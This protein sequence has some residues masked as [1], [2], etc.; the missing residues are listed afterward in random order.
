[1]PIARLKT[2]IQVA[3]LFF[4]GLLLSGCAAKPTTEFDSS[5]DF[6][7]PKSFAWISKNPLKV[8]E[9]SLPPN[10]RDEALLMD[11]T[12]S[13]LTTK[14]YTLVD[15]VN[16][17]DI[18]VAFRIG[19]REAMVLVNYDDFS[20]TAEQIDLYGNTAGSGTGEAVF[21]TYTD[22]QLAIDMFDVGTKRLIWRNAHSTPTPQ[23]ARKD[24]HA[25]VTT[26]VETILAEFPPELAASK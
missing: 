23:S 16:Q 11:A 24:P 6:S 9:D 7:P 8:D 20:A 17:A 18:A 26:E 3:C 12:A 25:I 1:M 15:D 14:G 22:G 21:A 10:P 5:Y 2:G 4:A 19:L 13:T